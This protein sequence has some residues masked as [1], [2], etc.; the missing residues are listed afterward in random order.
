MAE[1]RYEY[2]KQRLA[3]C[4]LHCGKCFAF[5]GGEIHELS[6][7]LRAALGNFVVFARRF[8]DLLG[9]PVYGKYPE[10]KAFLDHLA[11]RGCGGFRQEHCKLFASCGV[12]P[13]A[14]EHGVDFCFQCAEFPCDKTG[15]DEH[16]YR[17]HVEINRKMRET[18]VEAYYDAIKDLPRY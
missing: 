11:T 10:F 2:I 8:V 14:E 12:R 1:T 17:R 13:C 9:D 18:G 5:S 15:F 16:L 7:R 6:V 3:P 4:G